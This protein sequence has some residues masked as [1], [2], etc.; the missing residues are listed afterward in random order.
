MEL[1]NYGLICFNII[2]GGQEIIARFPLSKFLHM[3]D[4]ENGTD[5]ALIMIKID[6]PKIF[7]PRGKECVE[8]T[9]FEGGHGEVGHEPRYRVQILDDGTSAPVLMLE[10]FNASI[11]SSMAK[12]YATAA[13]HISTLEGELGRP[14]SWPLSMADSNLILAY[15]LNKGVRPSTANMSGTRRL[16]LSKG[17]EPAPESQLAKAL[18]K[19]YENLERDPAKAAAEAVHRPITSPL[20]GH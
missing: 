19:G 3:E 10:L 12:S 16:A 7:F 2:I 15:L 8:L 17:V 9:I 14:F 20:L 11:A 6:P 1:E 4:R 18:M 5:E 13:S